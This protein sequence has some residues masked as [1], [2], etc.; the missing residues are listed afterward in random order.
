MFLYDPL[1]RAYVDQRFFLIRLR[2]VLCGALAAGL[3]FSTT[4][5]GEVG[6]ISTVVLVSLV[7]R[8]VTALRFARILGVRR[9]DIALLKDVGKLTVAAAM[10]GSVAAGVRWPLMGAQPVVILLI[11]GANFGVTYLAAALWLGIATQEEQNFVRRKIVALI[12]GFGISG[13]ANDRG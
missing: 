8:V 5:F 10:A 11:V 9:S 2:V 3:W 12:P 4:R 7:E 6:A 13:R 1:Y